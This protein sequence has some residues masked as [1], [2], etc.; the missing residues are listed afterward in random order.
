MQLLNGP[1]GKVWMLYRLQ[2]AEGDSPAALTEFKDLG[3]PVSE[4]ERS[5]AMNPHATLDAAG[6]MHLVWDHFAQ[7]LYYSH[8][9]REG[10]WSDSIEIPANGDENPRRSH[11]QLVVRG[12]R[13]ALIYDGNQSAFLRRGEFKNGEPVFGEPIKIASHTARLIGTTPLTASTDR[14]MLLFGGNT[15]WTQSASVDALLHD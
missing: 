7:T 1:S 3:V 5:H 11:P 13:L 9:D 8:R 15:V 12:E 2:Y 10:A 4:Q 14:V 6:Q